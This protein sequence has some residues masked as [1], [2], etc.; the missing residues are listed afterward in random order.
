MCPSPF[1]SVCVCEKNNLVKK[2]GERS[3]IMDYLYLIMFYVLRSYSTIKSHVNSGI[4]MHYFL[5]IWREK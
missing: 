1:E 3:I 5:L 2:R 4:L